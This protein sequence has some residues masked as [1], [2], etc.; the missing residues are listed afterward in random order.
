MNNKYENKAQ[1]MAAQMSPDW[2]EEKL[3]R[4]RRSYSNAAEK[5]GEGVL[6]AGTALLVFGAPLKLVSMDYV[7]DQSNLSKGALKASFS[8]CLS[9]NT[10]TLMAAPAPARDSIISTCVQ[11]AHDKTAPRLEA[12]AEWTDTVGTTLLIAGGVI[13]ALGAKRIA[14]Y[15]VARKRLDVIYNASKI[16]QDMYPQ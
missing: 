8:S 14:G 12:I 15:C 9:E 16:S 13:A 4:A 7:D 11:A 1:E 5:Q 6:I 10:E 3:G 2:I